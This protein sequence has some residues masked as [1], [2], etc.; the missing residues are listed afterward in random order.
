MY[1]E[2]LI[3]ASKRVVSERFRIDSVVREGCIMSPLAVQHMYGCS[4]EGGEDGDGK[5]GKEWELPG[6]LYADDLVLW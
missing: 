5:E 4:D 6:L 1:V 3:C 2:N